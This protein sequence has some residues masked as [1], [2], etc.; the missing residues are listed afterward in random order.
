M[1]AGANEPKDVAYDRSGNLFVAARNGSNGRVAV[2][3]NQKTFVRYIGEG[4][5]VPQPLVLAFDQ[6]EN[7]LV[8][9]GG[10]VQKFSHDGTLID[11]FIHPA[12]EAIPEPV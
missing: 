4:Q 10:R 9:T 1:H 3:D 8:T 7:L 12:L 11:S 5:F 6:A 2:F